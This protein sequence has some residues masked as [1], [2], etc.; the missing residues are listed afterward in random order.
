GSVHEAA[1][2]E[3]CVRWVSLNVSSKSRGRPVAISAPEKVPRSAC[4]N[5]A[6]NYWDRTLACVCKALFELL[7]PAVHPTHPLRWQIAPSPAVA[8]MRYITNGLPRERA[9]ET[10]TYDN[11]PETI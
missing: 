6:R 2:A 10:P 7:L 11:H 4:K 3:S 1:S 9:D 5:N 8:L